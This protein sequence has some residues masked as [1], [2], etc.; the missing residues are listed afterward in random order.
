MPA[1]EPAVPKLGP[2]RRTNA[3][4]FA[5]LIR[6]YCGENLPMTAAHCDWAEAILPGR[7]GRPSPPQWTATAFALGMTRN[8]TSAPPTA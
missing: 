2:A 1:N 7:K 8:K 4:H 5:N 3:S 6:A